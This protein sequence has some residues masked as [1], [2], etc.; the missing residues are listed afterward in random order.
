[1]RRKEN[2]EWRVNALAVEDG[3]GFLQETQRWR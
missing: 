3:I 1:M 2:G